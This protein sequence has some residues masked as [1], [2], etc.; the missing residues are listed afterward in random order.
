MVPH[1]RIFQGIQHFFEKSAYIG[2]HAQN[3]P[4]L[5]NFESVIAPQIDD[6]PQFLLD[7]LK[8]HES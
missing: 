6:D 8:A 2:Y 7:I 3:K 4:N 1:D 5:A